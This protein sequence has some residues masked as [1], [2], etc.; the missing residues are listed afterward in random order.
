VLAGGY[1]FAENRAGTVLTVMSTSGGAWLIL[2][3]AGL[4]LFGILGIAI[5]WLVAS[6]IEATLFANALEQGIGV[7][8]AAQIA[9]PVVCGVVAAAVALGIGAA[10]GGGI[11]GMILGPVL[12]IGLYYLLLRCFRSELLSDTRRVAFR[13]VKD[14]RNA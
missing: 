11:A 8:A 6:L 10:I 4:A 1:L 5:G 2:G 9:P 14:L 13:T 3:L 12:A 7:Q